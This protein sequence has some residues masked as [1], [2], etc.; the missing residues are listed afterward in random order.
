MFSSINRLVKLLEERLKE[1]LP[2]TS[3]HL[4]TKVQSKIEFNFPESSKDAKKAS[5]LILLFPYSNNIHFFLTQRTLSVEHHK[6]QISL[7]GGTCEK[8]EK[9]INTALRETEEE[10][11]VDK[12]EVEIIGELTP[13]FT[14]TSG[15]IV[16]PFIGWCNRRPKTNKQTDEVHTLFSASLSQLLNDQ[17]LELEN[18]NLRGYETKVPFYNFDGHKVWGVTAAILSEFKLIL[19]DLT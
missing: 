11:G 13:F 16:H 19:N 6:G 14:P 7:P 8:N 5:V 9:T 15:F 2:G 10:I 12:N 17:I 1:P 4:I 18:W 3:A